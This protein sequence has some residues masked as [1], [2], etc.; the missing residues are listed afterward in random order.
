MDLYKRRLLAALAVACFV[1]A[2]ALTPSEV[3]SGISPPETPTAPVTLDVPHPMAFMRPNGDP[4]APRVAA[5]TTIAL[6]RIGP[7]PVNSGAGFV[8]FDVHAAS[9]STLMAVVLGPHPAAVIS[10]LGDT[11]VVALGDP[12]GGATVV[13]IDAAG[14]TLSD[15]RRLS[16]QPAGGNLR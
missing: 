8:P 9:P 16:L 7:L 5:D 15:A 3:R 13:S 4:F 14:V 1:G 6:Q 11:R 10:A 2:V 12:V